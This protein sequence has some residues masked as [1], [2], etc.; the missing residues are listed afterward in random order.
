V[1]QIPRRSAWDLRLRSHGTDRGDCGRVRPDALL[2]A[3]G[4]WEKHLVHRCA[5]IPAVLH[6]AGGATPAHEN[7]APPDSPGFIRPSLPSRIYPE[8]V[9]TPVHRHS[10]TSPRNPGLHSGERVM[11]R[12]ARNSFRFPPIHVRNPFRLS[13]VSGFST[14]TVMPHGR[15]SS[16]S[17]CNVSHGAAAST[18]A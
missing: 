16:H 14:N 13:I 17:G 18:P 15:N 5:Y 10:Q 1:A 12:Q 11:S 2:G 4:I 6:G 8:A 3:A 7:A 9:F